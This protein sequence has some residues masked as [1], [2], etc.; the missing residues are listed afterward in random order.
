MMT[1][2]PS[3]LVAVAAFF[4][5]VS[6][7]PTSPASPQTSGATQSTAPV[8]AQRALVIGMRIE[9]P[10][11][12]SRTFQPVGQVVATVHNLLNATLVKDDEAGNP[13]GE[14]ADGLPQ[15]DTDTW[16]VTPDG[17]MET[18]YHLRPG[19]VWHDG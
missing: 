2:R 6:C 15:V 19:L 7:A 16:K 3:L 8:A 13:S 1:L 9:P 12:I 4:I 18:T 11:A 14:L 5:L 17:H 10:L